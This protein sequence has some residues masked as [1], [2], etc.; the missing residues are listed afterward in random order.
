MCGI[1]GY[2]DFNRRPDKR[3]M[4]GMVRA[5]S[6]RGP[7]AQGVLTE[8]PCALVHARLSIIDVAGSPQPMRLADGDLS[9]VYNGE[10]Y[11]YEALRREL[12]AQGVAF[13][14]K[15][16]TEVVLRWIAHEGPAALPRFDA[17]FAFGIWDRRR[18]SLLLARDALGE[19]PLFYATPAPGILVFGSEIKAVVEHPAVDQGLN[20][21][22]L[23]QA[24]RFR[25]VYGPESLHRGVRQLEPGTYLEFDRQG[26]RTGRFYDLIA[27]VEQVRPA[28][29]GL[30]GSELIARG[31]DTLRF[32]Q[33]ILIGACSTGWTAAS[34]P[35]WASGAAKLSSAGNGRCHLELLTI[36]G[37]RR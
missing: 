16:D 33:E 3:V 12:Q 15:G 10:I 25:A 14:T 28:Y 18:E 13:Q 2:V 9:M 30:S 24:L 21:D 11:N 34:A 22:A 6:R 17:M 37:V 7:D 32:Q 8:G 31:R 20:E 27:E 23:R 4:D 5:L 19:K 26:L 1:A 29:A 36:H 35:W